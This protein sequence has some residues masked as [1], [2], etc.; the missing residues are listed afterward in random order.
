[1]KHILSL[2]CLVLIALLS[3]STKDSSVIVVD[4]DESY[5]LLNLKLSDV[6]DISYIPLK[7]NRDSVMFIN[8]DISKNIYV[9]K[10]EIIIGD[11]NHVDSKLLVYDRMGNLLHQIGRKGR[12]PGEFLDLFIFTADTITNEVIIYNRNDSKFIVYDINGNYLNEKRLLEGGAEFY[13]ME[14]IGQEYLVGYNY[15]SYYLAPYM[16]KNPLGVDAIKGQGKSLI[17]FNRKSLTCI[18]IRDIHYPRPY[19]SNSMPGLIWQITTTTEGAYITSFR[20]DTIFFIGRDLSV[21]P[22]FVDVTNYGHEDITIFP[23]METNKYIF[24]Y[25]QMEYGKRGKL[26]FFVYDKASNRFFRINNNISEDINKFN[27]RL[28]L[29]NNE[30]ALNQFTL[31]QNHDYAAILLTP[32]F[33]KD[34]YELLNNDLK[35]ITDRLE[36]YDNPVL[37]LMK[38]R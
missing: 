30:I 1:M 21:R 6:A 14:N 35:T 18:E 15:R 16:S 24:F 20:S 22:K 13:Q 7:S 29:I 37:M 11:R 23:T 3:C 27:Y 2:L 9:S 4:T 33:L 19:I 32:M 12:G 28:A 31:T 26:R 36:E 34:H 8:D 25:T 5:P 17:G 38:F 10:D